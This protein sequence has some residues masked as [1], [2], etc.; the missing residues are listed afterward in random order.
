LG[1]QNVNYLVLLRQGTQK[2]NK[3]I[4]GPEPHG[5]GDKKERP[6]KGQKMHSLLAGN[7]KKK[8]QLVPLVVGSY[9]THGPSNVACM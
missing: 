3:K 8:K 2:P 9:V 1:F 6:K 4:N 7:K 5:R